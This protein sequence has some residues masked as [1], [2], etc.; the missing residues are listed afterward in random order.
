MTTKIN[1]N[2]ENLNSTINNL[3][4][5]GFEEYLNTWEKWTAY[6]EKDMNHIIMNCTKG[7]YD[8]WVC[9][10]YFNEKNKSAWLT[11]SKQY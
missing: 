2:I 7:E 9:D 8:G 5:N 11:Y 3:I 1:I 4:S 10:I 6:D